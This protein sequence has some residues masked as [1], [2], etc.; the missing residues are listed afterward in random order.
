MAA[1]E[2]LCKFNQNDKVEDIQKMFKELY[3]NLFFPSG[4]FIHTYII[5]RRYIKRMTTKYGVR[6]RRL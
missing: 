1:S 5:Y 4:R 3:F 6:W 2:I